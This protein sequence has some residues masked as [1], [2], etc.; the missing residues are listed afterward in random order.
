MFIKIS[1]KNLMFSDMIYG[2]DMEKQRQRRKSKRLGGSSRGSITVMVTLLL[3]P[4]IF[5]TGFMV[6]FARIKLMSDQAVMAADNYGEAVISQYDNL[7][8][9]LYGLFAVTQN[10]D[11]L[12]ALDDI[13]KYIGYSF[14]PGGDGKVSSG[15]MPYQSAEVEVGYQAVEG[16]N[17][18]N[19]DVF[20]TQVGDFMKFRVAQQLLE[21]DGGMLDTVE[22]IKNSKADAEVSQTQMKLDEKAADAVEAMRDFYVEL[23]KIKSYPDY[24]GRMRTAVLSAKTMIEA[25]VGSDDYEEYVTLY[26]KMNYPEEKEDSA[27]EEDTAVDDTAADDA[28]ESEEE[29]SQADADKERLEEL[30]E[31]IQRKLDQAQNGVDVSVEYEPIDFDTFPSSADRLYALA[32][33]VA[34]E[35]SKLEELA[36]KLRQQLSQEGITDALKEG[37]QEDLT[38][39][40][41]LTGGMYDGQNYRQ[42]A[43]YI[44]GNKDVN[45]DYHIRMQSISTAFETIAENLMKNETE[46][47]EYPLPDDVPDYPEPIDK[48]QWYDFYKTTEY[49]NIYDSLHKYFGA[50]NEEKE[51]EAKQKKKDAEKLR[52]EIDEEMK[53]EETSDARNIPESFGL[54]QTNA[55]NVKDF[56]MADAFKDIAGYFGEG[57]FSQAGNDILQKFLMAQYDIGMFTDR[58]TNVEKPSGGNSEEPDAEGMEG[59]GEAQAEKSLVGVKFA[60]NVNYLYQAELEYLFSS[61][62]NSSD[63]LKETR[64]KIVLFRFMMNFISTYSIKEIRRAITAVSDLAGAINPLLGMAV[65]GALHMAVAS[66]ESA[67]DWK[68]LKAGESV[69]VYKTKLSQMSC[70]ESIKGLI[71]VEAENGTDTGDAEGFRLNYHQYMQVM[72]IFMTS[73]DKLAVRTSNLVMLN[74][75][76]VQQRSPEE[77]TE[78]QFKMD[79]AFTAVDAFCKVHL[80]FV[81]MPDGFAQKTIDAGTYS[82]VKD[83]E[84]YSYKFTVTRGY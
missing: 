34:R 38:K 74:V 17:L 33:D 23:K 47:L 62:Y 45:D 13:Q 60:E 69:S 11:G 82:S 41:E 25:I 27:A 31:L 8:K 61:H 43:A 51:K 67:G 56:H 70:L 76:N 7:L 2:G 15:F 52:D 55:S 36:D 46:P 30:E 77:L 49:K 65:N 84:K 18:A 71:N 22:K 81:V 80:D 39:L 66:V 58:V 35:L 40:D 63:N 68:Q 44:L 3:V 26:N 57:S 16:A 14:N 21:S 79:Q 6:D 64:N 75:N 1:K 9:E 53:G 54:E 29:D 19:E 83:F 48:S 20:V 5:F 12:K 37:I 72:L 42:M 4:T 73:M 10:E 50:Q 32:G 28:E 78:L 24:I 59:S